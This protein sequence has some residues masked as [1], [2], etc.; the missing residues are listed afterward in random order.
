MRPE[1]SPRCMVLASCAHAIRNSAGATAHRAADVATNSRDQLTGAEFTL[2]PILTADA[3]AAVSICARSL[4]A[5]TR[6]SPPPS[7]RPGRLV[8]VDQGTLTG[9]FAGEIVARVTEE[10]FGALKAAPI[11]VTLHDIPTLTTRAIQL[12]YYPI[13]GHIVAASCRAGWTCPRR[14]SVSKSSFDIGIAGY[15]AT[16]SYHCP[17]IRRMGPRR[18][19]Y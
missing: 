2:G 15:K 3:F 11:R 5:T 18:G 14:S 9:G 4:P 8:A 12:Y 19:A 7:A 10:A 6:P 13:H 1:Q 17:A 16:K